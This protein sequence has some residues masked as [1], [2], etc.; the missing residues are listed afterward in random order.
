MDA[1][2]TGATGLVG[3]RLVSQLGAATVLGRDPTRARIRFGP[4]V[5]AL[6]WSPERGP[7]PAEA[8]E[9]RD[10]IFHLAGEPVAEGRW[11]P[12][13]KRRIRDSRVLGTRNL[14][15]GIRALEQRPLVLVAASAV[16]YYGER[17]DE[18]LTESSSVASD[19]LAGVCLAWEA[20]SLEA[21]E[22]GLRV[23]LARIGVVLAPDGGALA[24]MLPFFRLGLGGPLGNGRQW[25]PWVH[26]DDVVGLLLH[27]ARSDAVSGPMNAVAPAP[28]TNRDFTSALGRAL[29]RPTLVPVP[30]LGLR[31]ALGELSQVLLASQRVVPRVAQ[32]TGY[33]FRHPELQ[34]ALDACIADPAERQTPRGR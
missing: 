4:G 8:I 12:A 19:F 31:V 1:L 10:V 33:R 25:M 3:G 5:D 7:P 27:A 9:G 14:V 26:V 18:D 24:R 21:A 23:V 29:R 16:G 11:T 28:V 34:A 13:K 30:R 6:Q 15:A 2:V 32:S 17:G 20:E 22:L